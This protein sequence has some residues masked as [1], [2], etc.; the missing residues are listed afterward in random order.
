LRSGA[1][2]ADAAADFPRSGDARNLAR[3]RAFVGGEFA[4]AFRRR[5]EHA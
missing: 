5:R 4:G 2:A 3:Y 1:F